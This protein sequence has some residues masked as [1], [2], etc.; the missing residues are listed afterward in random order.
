MRVRR[1]RRQLENIGDTDTW[2]Q[3]GTDD[4]ADVSDV[5]ARSTQK[6]QPQSTQVGCNC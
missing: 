2:D 4:N 5:Q 3:L 6:E 1:R